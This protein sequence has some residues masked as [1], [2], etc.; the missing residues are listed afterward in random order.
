MTQ[1]IMQRASD[2]GML[3]VIAKSKRWEDLADKYPR[4]IGW[5]DRMP[6]PWIRRNNDPRER[7]TRLYATLNREF[8][9]LRAPIPAYPDD[10]QDVGERYGVPIYSPI[11][12]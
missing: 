8:P 1:T 9:D 5:L 4:L 2:P 3:P 6:A 11:K 7:V 12:I 10:I